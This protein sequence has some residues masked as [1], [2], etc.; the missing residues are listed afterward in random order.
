MDN[1]IK[2]C[3]DDC[4]FLSQSYN[5]GVERIVG[6]KNNAEFSLYGGFNDTTT[7]LG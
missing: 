7:V 2:S 3:R 1:Q 6:L 5:D 4:D